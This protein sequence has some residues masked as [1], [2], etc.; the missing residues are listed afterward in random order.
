MTGS[1]DKRAAGLRLERMQASPRYQQGRFRNIHPIL[2]ELRRGTVPMPAIREFLFGR[3]LRRPAGPLP[4]LDPRETLRRAPESGL[5]VTWLGHSTLLVEIDGARLLTDPVWG[6]RL[7]PVPL[8]APRRFHPVP[9]EIEALPPLDAVLISHDHFDHL[10]RGSIVRLAKLGL[11]FV[12]SL[13]VGKY[14][15]SWGVP[16][17]SIIELDWWETHEV[18]GLRVTATPSQHFSGRGTG[19]NATQW[20]SLAVRGPKSSFFFSG[21]TGLTTQFREIREKLG[22]FDLVMLEVGAYHAAWSDIHLGPANALTALD[23]LGGGCFLPVHWGTFD[24][25]LHA[26]DDPAEQLLTLAPQRG[27]QMVMPKL[28]EVIEPVRIQHLAPKPW[29][30]QVAVREQSVPVDPATPTIQ[31]G[32]EQTDASLPLPID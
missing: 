20:A 31:T 26:W 30:R 14:L 18:A 21:D 32:A 3:S 28:G 13:G 16:E 1:T 5:R 6:E 12:T 27:V 11:P 22:P 17:A 10:D 9:L 25:A 19:T 7:S 15:S 23:W 29:W 8:V 24:L 2:P 4:V